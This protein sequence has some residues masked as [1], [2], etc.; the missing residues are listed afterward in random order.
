MSA[1]AIGLI[2]AIREEIR[3]FLRLVRSFERGT[4]GP[5]WSCRFVLGGAACI[6]VESGM[7]R[8][9]GAAAA[10]ALLAGARLRWVVSFG[11]AGA[12]RQDLE[13][14]DV[15]EVKQSYVLERG[16]LGGRRPL[17][18]LPERARQAAAS[19]LLSRGAR[20][21]PGT[22]ITTGGEQA[23]DTGAEI[24]NPVLEMETDAIAGACAAR[25]IPLLGLR[26]ISD[27][28][29]EPLP[30][31][32]KERL[33]EEQNIRI[34]ALLGDI[35]RRPWILPRLVRS[36]GNA[37]RASENLAAALYALVE[38]LPGS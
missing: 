34:G 9:R 18:E 22:A 5:F 27:S 19:V 17:H 12:V 7:G 6:L 16:T 14:G 1:G 24:D 28:P 21:V 15:V 29:R 8:A 20:L 25:G 36:A 38:A 35:V 2:A 4:V 30:F 26:A 23:A 31:D 3:P 11:V 33:D 37:R 10:E 13:V 32:L